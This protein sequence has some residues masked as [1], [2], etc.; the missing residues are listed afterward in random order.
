MGEMSKSRW[1]PFCGF[2]GDVMSTAL[3]MPSLA[4]VVGWRWPP[5]LGVARCVAPSV[6]ERVVEVSRR[7]RVAPAAAARPR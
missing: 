7:H 4:A 3:V 1:K 6:E 5:A 2:H